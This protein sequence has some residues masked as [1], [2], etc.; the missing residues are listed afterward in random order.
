MVR[1]CCNG[2][3]PRSKSHSGNCRR[4]GD[5]GLNCSGREKFAPQVI[6]WQHD[7]RI[8]LTVMRFRKLRIA[9]SV[10]WGLVAVLLVVLWVRSYWRIDMYAT[11]IGGVNCIAQSLGVSMV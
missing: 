11:P 5:A 2:A 7:V 9:W 6:S 10:G 1:E 8:V 4:C 3:R